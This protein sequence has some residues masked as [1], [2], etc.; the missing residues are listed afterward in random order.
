MV[1]HG[2]R[3]EY[4]IGKT[5][6]PVRREGELRVQLPEQ[7]RPVHYIATDDPSGV[8]AYWHN[9]FAPKRKEGEWFALSAQDVAAFK[10]WKRIS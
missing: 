8:E 1:K 5:L 9:R 4:K 10:K 7:L 6:N 2:S 3:P